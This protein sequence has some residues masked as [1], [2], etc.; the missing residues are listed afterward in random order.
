MKLGSISLWGADVE[1]FLGEIR[2]AD[3][4][5]Y[6][7]ITVGDS[8][9]A[10]QDV[11]VSLAVAAPATR[12]AIL[13]PM[14]TAPYLRH[15]MMLAR[16]MLS[17]AQLCDGRVVIGLGYGGS[18]TASIGRPAASL[19]Y[20]RDFVSALRDLLNGESIVWDGMKCSPL[21]GAHPIPIYIAAEGPKALRMA[22]AIADGVVVT[23]GHNLDIVDHRLAGARAG[24]LDAGRDPDQLELWGMGYVSVRPSRREAIDDISAFLA[25]HGGLG[26]Q[27]PYMR[28]MVPPELDGKLQQ[29]I[30]AYSTTE[31]TVVGGQQAQLVERLGLTDFLAGLTS[32]VGTA[33]EVKAL[34]AV[35]ETRG[36]SC[37]F[38]PLPGNVDPLGTLRRFHDAVR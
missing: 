19:A 26:M 29:L 33:D 12:K 24:A 21:V 37:V 17:L 3:E 32:L 34:V 5:G 23:V 20:L 13:A 10:W 27:R 15:P 35:L 22:G 18:A 2:L 14:V 30:D 7:V 36:M 6:E 31:H 1:S 16:S 8:P 4:L 9:S 25:V 11:Y 28:A 38:A